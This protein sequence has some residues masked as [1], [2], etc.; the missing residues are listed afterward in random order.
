ME[1]DEHTDGKTDLG[2]SSPAYPALVVHV[3]ISTTIADTS[4]V[5]KL[6]CN[7][8]DATK[9]SKVHTSTVHGLL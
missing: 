8:E 7:V 5:K 1:V 2:A 3:P 4:S 6:R 9:E